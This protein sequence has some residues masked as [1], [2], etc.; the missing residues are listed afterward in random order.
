MEAA[1]LE[2]AL[3]RRDF[4]NLSDPPAPQPS[5]RLCGVLPSAAAEDGGGWG[6]CAGARTQGL[7]A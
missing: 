4:A 7:R 6:A 3:T 1:P 2:A 5:R